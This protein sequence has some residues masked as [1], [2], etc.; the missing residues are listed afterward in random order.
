MID[1]VKD[2]A[3]VIGCILS[4]I[5]L[6]TLVVKPLREGLTKWVMSKSNS[7]EIENKID[8]LFAML[9]DRKSVV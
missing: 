8:E 1:T 6:I 3:T 2:I 4:F 7:C 9:E 5:T